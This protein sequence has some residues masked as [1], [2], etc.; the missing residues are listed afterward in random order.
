[1]G[2]QLRIN[3]IGHTEDYFF[4]AVL[5]S[6]SLDSPVGRPGMW[7]LLD[8]ESL[9]I[10]SLE[11]YS[12]SLATHIV[13]LFNNI[14]FTFYRFSLRSCNSICWGCN[15]CVPCYTGLWVL[16][17]LNGPPTPLCVDVVG[18]VS[19]VYCKGKARRNSCFLILS[20]I[21]RISKNVF[22]KEKLKRFRIGYGQESVIMVSQNIISV[23]RNKGRFLSTQLYFVWVFP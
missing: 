17:S 20:S 4:R 12:V 18:E 23:S 13:F 7:H 8:S 2:T 15:C 19:F 9:V 10:I 14:G 21:F 22:Y 16:I 3:Q 1:M 6:L 5:L 11:N